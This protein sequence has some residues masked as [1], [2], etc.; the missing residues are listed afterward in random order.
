[1]WPNIK[2]W[3]LYK[4]TEIV[5]TPRA[6][7]YSRTLADHTYEFLEKAVLKYITRETLKKNRAAQERDA[8]KQ[9]ETSKIAEGRRH[10][11]FIIGL[12]PAAPKQRKACFA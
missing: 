11:I 4:H 9:A 1:M 3:E 6:A 5:I 12:L 10:L 2:S 8:A 7:H